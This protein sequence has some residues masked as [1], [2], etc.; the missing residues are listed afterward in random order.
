MTTEQIIFNR[1]DFEKF[2]KWFEL[3]QGYDEREFEEIEREDI[4]TFVFREDD[5][6]VEKIKAKLGKL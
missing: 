2:M 4:I 1:E 5:E 3:K 6:I